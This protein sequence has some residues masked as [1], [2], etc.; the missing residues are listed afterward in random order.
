M[1][2]YISGGEDFRPSIDHYTKVFY[3]HRTLIARSMVFRYR[4]GIFAILIAQ[5]DRYESFE[6]ILDQL[7]EFFSA[8]EKGLQFSCSRIRSP[9]DGLD[10]PIRESYYTF[11]ASRAEERAFYRFDRI[12]EYQL[13]I[14]VYQTEIARDYAETLPKPLQGREDFFDTAKQLIPNEG[15][16]FGT[17]QALNCHHNTIRYR[18]SRIKAIL[19]PKG[20]S[21]QEFYAR[22][23]LTV[24]LYLLNRR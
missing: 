23:S 9:Y 2:A 15:D 7:R 14:P 17:A 3:L 11:L 4:G 24:R 6:L 13:L 22:L 20:I 16:I 1:A 10:L 19:F 5:Q 8:D 18:L 12:G 21:E